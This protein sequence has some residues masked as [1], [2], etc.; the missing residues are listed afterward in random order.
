MGGRYLV[1]VDLGSTSLKSVVYDLC[2]SVVASG[3]RPTERFHPDPAHPEWTVWDPAQI[4]G[5]AAAAIRDA[6]GRTPDLSQVAAVSVT[7]MGMDG[8]PV[9]E[10]GRWLYP[11]ISWLC[12]RTEPQ[13]A[14]WEKTIG[15]EKTF[16][17]GGNNLWAFSTALRLL[18]MAEHEPAILSRTHK[19]L[20]IEDFPELHALRAAG[21][22][23]QHGLVHAAVR[24]VLPLVVPPDAR[25]LG[26]R[27][28]SPVRPPAQRN[29]ARRSDPRCFGGHRP[30]GGHPRGPGRS[31]L[32][33][34]RA[35]RRG[36]FPGGIPGR[37]R[38]VGSRAGHD[39]KAG[40]YPG[41]SS[42]S[43]PRWSATWRATST[44]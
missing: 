24:P 25:T 11:F 31:R 21:H 22:G 13:R 8:V 20:L 15:K 27:R 34:R 39:I 35:S 4:W 5:G 32:P 41:S 38:H 43:V 16:S 26:D 6:L 44:R 40:P 29:R 18:W 36:A 33:V 30:A 42:A 23:L 10:Q 7:G 1:G 37:E 9:D 14:W 17:V 19:W 3:S 28:P 2:G 12:P